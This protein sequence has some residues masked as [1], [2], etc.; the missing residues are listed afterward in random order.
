MLCKWVII[1]GTLCR[2][3]CLETKRSSGETNLRAAQ[4]SCSLQSWCRFSAMWQSQASPDFSTSMHQCPCC[5]YFY[6]HIFHIIIAADLINSSE[7][8]V[9]VRL[10][11]ISFYLAKSGVF[12]SLV[13]FPFFLKLRLSSSWMPLDLSLHICF[14]SYQFYAVA[15]VCKKKI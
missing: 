1:S 4:C 9:C 14:I 5:F 8:F 13:V 6:V 10:S 11:F 15:Y 7:H 2:V 12:I 3:T